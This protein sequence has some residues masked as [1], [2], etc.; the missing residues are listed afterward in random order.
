M[1]VM[2]LVLLTIQFLT[3]GA[4]KNSEERSEMVNS[5][6]W[7]VAGIAAWLAVRTPGIFGL[8]TV[9]N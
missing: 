1:D 2:I 7:L 8:F 9:T 6:I 4:N 3:K 5:F